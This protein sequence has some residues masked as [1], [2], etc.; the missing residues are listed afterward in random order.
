MDVD[1]LVRMANQIAANFEGGSDENKAV[2]SVTDHIKRFW[3]PLM[4]KQIIVRWKERP[5]DLTPRA[6]AAIEAIAA[7]QTGA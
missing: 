3:S 2:A 6:A 1:K 5:G 4:K 7:Q